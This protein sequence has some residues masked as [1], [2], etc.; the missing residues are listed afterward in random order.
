MFR[1]L[2]SPSVTWIQLA[3]TL[4]DASEVGGEYLIKTTN[5]HY[6]FEQWKLV[7]STYMGLCSLKTADGLC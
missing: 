7:Y 3:V 2:T 5:S 6:S 1:E 4:N